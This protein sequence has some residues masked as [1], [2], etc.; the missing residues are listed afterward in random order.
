[1]ARGHLIEELRERHGYGIEAFI[2]QCQAHG[3]PIGQSEYR[4]IEAGV[5]LPDDPGAFVRAASAV[6]PLCADE[7][8]AL[9]SELATLILCEAYGEEVAAWMLGA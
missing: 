6:L 9:V 7:Q 2:A 4:E 5:R 8:L 3:R 1:M